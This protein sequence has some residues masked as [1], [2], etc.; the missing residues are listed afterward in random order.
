MTN[1]TVAPPTGGGSITI[2]NRVYTAAAGASV[3]MPEDDA[4]IARANGW[5]IIPAPVVTLI[6]ESAGVSTKAAILALLGITGLT[7]A[8]TTI[9][10][11]V[12]G[13]DLVSRSFVMPL[14]A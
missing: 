10:V 8:D 9:T 4:W 14:E 5:T 13:V 1:V 7:A 6:S 2:Q 12:T 3:S 11:S